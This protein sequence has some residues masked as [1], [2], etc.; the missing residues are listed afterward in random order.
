MALLLL[1]GLAP[2]QRFDNWVAAPVLPGGAAAF[3]QMATD[4]ASG[5]PTMLIAT[6]TTNDTATWNGTSFAVAAVT[7]TPAPSGAAEVL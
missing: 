4:P 6:A 2:A 7:G 3:S 5:A 1:A